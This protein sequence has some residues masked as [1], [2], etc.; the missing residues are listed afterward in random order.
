MGLDKNAIDSLQEQAREAARFSYSPY[1]KFRVGAALLASDGTVYRGANIENRS[2]GLANC[3]ERSA[4]FLALSQGVTSFDAIAIYSPDS[5]EMLT[6]CG[7]CRQVLSEFV[8]PDFPVYCGSA[9]GQFQI[10][11]M[12]ELLPYDALRDF[13]QR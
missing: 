9:D 13:R 8:G 3:A 12:K 10:I 11:A 2:Y 7:A 4:V 1:S 5:E 6:P